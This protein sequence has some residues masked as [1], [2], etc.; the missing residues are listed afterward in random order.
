MKT[1][2]LKEKTYELLEEIKEK[3][4][5]SSFNELILNMIQKTMKTPP[6]LF[7]SLKGTKY[8]EKNEYSF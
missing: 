3:Q 4:K 6:S 8:G 2:A 7:G 5:V 1:I